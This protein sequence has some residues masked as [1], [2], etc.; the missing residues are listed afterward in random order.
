MR[1][2]ALF[3]DLE[4]QLAAEDLAALDADVAERADYELGRL[5]LSDRLRGAVGGRL[6]VGVSGAGAV[7]GTL[8]EVGADW[9][10]L[11]DAAGREAIVATGAISTVAGLTARSA[12]PDS[13]GRPVVRIGL[14]N[15]LRGLA[16]DRSTVRMTQ[17]DSGTVTGTI[18]T[19]GADFV[20]VAEH[21]PGEPR[22]AG[23]VRAVRAVALG[24]LAVVRPA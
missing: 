4:G 23:R 3:A 12:D 18:D 10:L 19:V 5:H 24:A 2:E 20:E 6:V 11:R 9:L 8:A 15:A 13:S 14:R 1:W 21:L 7:E 16:R 17:R 22:R